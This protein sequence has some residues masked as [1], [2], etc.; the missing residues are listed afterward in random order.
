ML[1]RNRQDFGNREVTIPES[2]VARG[3]SLQRIKCIPHKESPVLYEQEML[4][5]VEGILH[6]ILLILIFYL[7]P[8]G[9]LEPPFPKGRR[10]LSCLRVIPNC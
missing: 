10:I 3:H 9:G 4:L 6:L 1:R 7:V 2:S 8:G 5:E